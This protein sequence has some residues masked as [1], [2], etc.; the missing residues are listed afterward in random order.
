MLVAMSALND[1]WHSEKGIVGIILILAIT[2]LVIVGSV[3]AEQWTDYTKWVFG[4]Y[5]AGK[6]VQGITAKTPLSSETSATSTTTV[7]TKEA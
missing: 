2:A 5:V 3:T 4:I 1:L 6:T 7:V